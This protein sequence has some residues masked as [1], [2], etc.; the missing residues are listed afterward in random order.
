MSEATY[1][2]VWGVLSS[3]NI[4]DHKNSKNGL[5][6]LSWAWAWSVLMDH[7]P[8]A[9]YEFTKYDGLDVLVYP[10]GTCS[11]ECTIRIGDLSRS[12]WLPVMDYKNHPI[13]NPSARSIS[14]SK[15]RCLVKCIGMFGLGLY[16]YA[17]EDLPDDRKEKATDKDAIQDH[18]SWSGGEP[19]RFQAV[20]GQWD[21]TYKKLVEYLKEKDMACPY[22][23][24]WT[25]AKRNKLLSRLEEK[26]SAELD[27]QLANEKL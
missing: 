9:R 19:E 23:S 17:G 6:Y 7:F 13:P 12:M 22:P 16:I 8:N 2:E 27:R 5:A 15:M 24:Q 4:N 10:D 25:Q 14:A 18:S 20:I 1:S 21:W 11:V 26:Y 3:I